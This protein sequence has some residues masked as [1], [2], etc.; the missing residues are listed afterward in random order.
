MKWISVKERLPEEDQQVLVYS[1]DYPMEVM[2]FRNNKFNEYY[3]DLD[4]KKD[5]NFEIEEVT[6]WMPIPEPPKDQ[7]ECC[8]EFFNWQRTEEDVQKECDDLFPNLP[9]EEK[10]T[11]CEPCFIKIMDFNEP[12]KYRYKKYIQ[13]KE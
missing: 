1:E 10:R 5:Y 6:H 13:D 4:I 11:V 12:G 8:L 7:C 3:E 2:W 9:E